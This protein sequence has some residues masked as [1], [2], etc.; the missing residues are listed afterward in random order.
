MEVSLPAVGVS[1]KRLRELALADIC[2]AVGSHID[3]V[4]LF[5]LPNSFVDLFDMIRDAFDLLDGTVKR[6][7]PVLHIIIPQSQLDQVFQQVLVHYYKFSA[8]YTTNVDIGSVRFKRSLLPR[9]CDVEAVGMG[10]TSNELRMPCLITSAFR[11]YRS[12][13][14]L[15][16]QRSNWNSP[17]DV[18]EPGNVS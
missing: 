8:Q 4:A 18:G 11:V 1:T 15:A 12:S 9:I 3:Q 17:L 2:A 14:G 13:G 7:D 16:Q 6:D 10:A 5:D